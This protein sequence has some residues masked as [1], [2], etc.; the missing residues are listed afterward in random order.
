[1][2]KKGRDKEERR[3]REKGEIRE[4]GEGER[5]GREER[6]RERRE[7]ERYFHPKSLK[8]SCQIL[9]FASICCFS[10]ELKRLRISFRS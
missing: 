6:E 10:S 1:M 4:K 9:T 3:G 2:E 7:G 8:F 5:R